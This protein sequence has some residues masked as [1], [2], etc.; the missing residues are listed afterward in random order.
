MASGSP[1]P[2][3]QF[4][5]SSR[6]M[7]TYTLLY[8]IGYSYSIFLET[9][10]TG[11]TEEGPVTLARFDDGREVSG[12]RCWSCFSSSSSFFVVVYTLLLYY[13]FR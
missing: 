9:L 3:D 2:F 5:L 12:R 13:E 6:T 10:E 11:L 4:L 7:Y 1:M 8:N